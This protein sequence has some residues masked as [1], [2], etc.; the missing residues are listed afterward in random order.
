[1][2]FEWDK[3]KDTQNRAK[4]GIGLGEAMGLDWHKAYDSPDTRH[5]YGERRV[6]ALVP[7]NGRIHVCI[8]TLRNSLCRVI[9]LRKANAREVRQYERYDTR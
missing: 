5:D 8:Y 2:E 4:H 9:S 3:E 6:I 1:M 7:L